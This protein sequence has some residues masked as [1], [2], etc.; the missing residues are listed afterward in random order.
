MPPLQDRPI[1]TAGALE[2]DLAERVLRVAGAPA[3]VGARA[4]QI[5]EILVQ[6]A[7]ELVARSDLIS[8]VWPEGKIAENTL[9][10]HISALRLALG[11]ERGVLKTISGR[12]YRL[13]GSWTAVPPSGVGATPA[14]QI[15]PAPPASSST[16]LPVATFALI[17]R[18]AATRRVLGLV[19]T[20]RAIMLT[21]PGG[22]GK[23]VLALEVARS[24]AR[25]LRRERPAGRAGVAIRPG[26]GC[27]R[28][29]QSPRP[30]ARFQRIYL[31]LGRAGDR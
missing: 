7:G 24:P 3:Q 12:G 8:R 20:S 15:E 10:A 22:I 11:A 9:E 13:L 19:S 23:T 31:L 6:S 28:R 21:G 18:A 26:A 4:F 27:R 2:V 16:N 17:G 5:L 25:E 14:V 1:Y 30:Q 29:C